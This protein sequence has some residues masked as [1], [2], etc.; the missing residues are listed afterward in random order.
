MS[1]AFVREPDEFPC[2]CPVCQTT[3]QP[4]G[5]ETLNAQLDYDVRTSLAESAYFCP[6]AL[7]DVVYFDDYSAVVSRSEFKQLIPIKDAEAPICSCFGLKREDIELDVAEG[8]VARTKAAVL[9]A[10]SCDA[11]CMTKSPNGRSCVQE[12]QCYYIKHKQRVDIS[13]NQRNVTG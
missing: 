2:R 6:D 5:P 7:C 9:K 11:R 4:V 3:G 10:Q 8:T 13:R 12:L 1:K